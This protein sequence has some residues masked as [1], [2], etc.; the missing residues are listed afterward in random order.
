M[1]RNRINESKGK[2]EKEPKLV[3]GRRFAIARDMEKDIQES[4]QREIPKKENGRNFVKE[5]TR[6]K[7]ESK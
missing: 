6:K 1:V 3:N 5:N 2:I 4:L 7:Q